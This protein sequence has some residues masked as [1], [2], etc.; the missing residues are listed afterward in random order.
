MPD[1][2][3]GSI[4]ILTAVSFTF[5]FVGAGMAV[6]YSR[7]ARQQRALNIAIDAA[8]LAVATSELTSLAELEEVAENYV[9]AN[10]GGVADIGEIDLELSVDDDSVSI[11]PSRSCRPRS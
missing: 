8:A 9:K 7:A 5:A 11:K 10:L 6:D 2:S 4:S 3:L 1:K